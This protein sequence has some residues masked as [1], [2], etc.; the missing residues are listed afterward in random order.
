M[1][2]TRISSHFVSETDSAAHN[3]SSSGPILASYPCHTLSIS[4]AASVS[5]REFVKPIFSAKVGAADLD[6]R[7]R[8]QRPL[9]LG[10]PTGSLEN[11]PMKAA[12]K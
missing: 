4:K 8:T 12:G 11:R 5:Y 9:S 2:G 7:Y 10:D 3:L 6:V 1:K